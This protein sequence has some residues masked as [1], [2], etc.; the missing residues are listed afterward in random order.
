VRNQYG[1]G[2]GYALGAVVST[3][4]DTAKNGSDGDVPDTSTTNAF[5]W[6]DGALQASISHKPNVNDNQT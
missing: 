6:F 1:S 3:T 5:V 2:T 4:S